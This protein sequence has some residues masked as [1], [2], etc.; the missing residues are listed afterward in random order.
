MVEGV[1][2]GEGETTVKSDEDDVSLEME[3]REPDFE[4]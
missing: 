2:W 3:G 4:I 1:G